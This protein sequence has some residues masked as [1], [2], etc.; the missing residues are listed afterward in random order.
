MKT[1]TKV[2]IGLLI[3][4]VVLIGYDCYLVYQFKIESDKLI[5]HKTLNEATPQEIEMCL[6]HEN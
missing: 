5:C 1:G 6:S 2:L 4:G 3:F